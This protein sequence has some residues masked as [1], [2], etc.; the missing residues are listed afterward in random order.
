MNISKY[1]MSSI[2]IEIDCHEYSWKLNGMWWIMLLR[3]YIVT[4]LFDQ[5]IVRFIIILFLEWTAA[6]LDS[7]RLL[8]VVFGWVYIVW[9]LSL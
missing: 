3:D 1:G 2:F 6:G 5:A 7:E 4:L 9:R 8:T